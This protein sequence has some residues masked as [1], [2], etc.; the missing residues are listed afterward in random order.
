MDSNRY[1]WYTQHIMPT[2][3]TTTKRATSPRKRKTAPEASVVVSTPVPRSEPVRRVK[4]AFMIGMLLLGIFVVAGAVLLGRSD[5]G[6]IDVAATVRNAAPT[7]G[8]QAHTVNVP[9]EAFRNMTNGGLVPQDAD[10]DLAPAS[11]PEATTASTTA[12]TTAV[13]A[14]DASSSTEP[15]QAE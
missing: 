8:E 3:R 7:E 11:V 4:P 10:T 15:T 5:T 2:V 6:Q 12:T 9:S 13:E 1:E 14:V